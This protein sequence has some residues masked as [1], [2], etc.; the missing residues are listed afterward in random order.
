M[1]NLAGPLIGTNDT[2]KVRNWKVAKSQIVLLLLILFLILILL[3][4]K[5]FAP[6]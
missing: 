1:A 5:I 2:G 6:P 4:V 3:L